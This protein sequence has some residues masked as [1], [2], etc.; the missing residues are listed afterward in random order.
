MKITNVLIFSIKYI[1]VIIG[2]ACILIATFF[3]GWFPIKF[4]MIYFGTWLLL[5]GLAM[6]YENN[7]H[8]PNRA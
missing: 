4:P 8:K 2:I 6:I 5:M 1:C 7:K 3:K